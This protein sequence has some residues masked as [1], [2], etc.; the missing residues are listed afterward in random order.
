MLKLLGPRWGCQAHPGSVLCRTRWQVDPRELGSEGREEDRAVRLTSSQLMR[1][2]ED[3]NIDPVLER[4]LL[5]RFFNGGTCVLRSS[6]WAGAMAVASCTADA[7]YTGLHLLGLLG[8]RWTTQ[9]LLGMRCCI[10]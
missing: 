7:R 4:F 10:A 2:S 5:L 6:G 1:T 3:V 9:R 8:C